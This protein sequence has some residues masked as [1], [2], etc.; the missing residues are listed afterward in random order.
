[1]RALAVRRWWISAGCALFV[2]AFVFWHFRDTLSNPALL[3]DD[4]MNIA[5]AVNMSLETNIKGFLAPNNSYNNRPLG[6]LFFSSCS[7][8]FGPNPLP[9]VAVLFGLHLAN[10]VLGF[11]LASRLLENRFLGAVCALAWAMNINLANNSYSA[12]LLYDNLLFFWWTAALLLY[13]RMRRNPNTLLY[14]GAL[15]CFFLSTRCKE[16]G[17]ML[18][19]LLL[20]YELATLEWKACGDG[21]AR[22][23]QL[24]HRL[25]LLAP[26]F[27][28][29][30]LYA[31]FY[32]WQ[33]EW[34]PGS[35]PSHPYYMNLS[36]GAFM[37]G[38]KFYVMSVTFYQSV[39]KTDLSLYVALFI[40]V[41]WALLLRRMLVLW[42]LFGF[43]VTLLPVIFLVNSR[44][45]IYLYLPLFY[46]VLILTELI[47]H[48]A[49]RLMAKWGRAGVGIAC[50]FLTALFWIYWSEDQRLL[51]YIG[52]AYQ[53]QRLEALTMVRSIKGFYP[54]IPAGSRFY[55]IGKPYHEPASIILA[56]TMPPV[57]YG[58]PTIRS[59]PVSGIEEILNREASEPDG[60]F[61]VFQFTGK[62]VDLAGGDIIRDRTAEIRKSRAPRL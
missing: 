30:L 14:V 18:P 27:V 37:E 34:G 48:T 36:Y 1:M 31:G 12:N 6:N 9:F 2:L 61:F 7:R 51:G 41:L 13:L 62:R 55:F 22:W 16:V 11:F 47:G 42:A 3:S 59:A 60:N 33:P 29:S 40:I 17:V 10:T 56:S 25:R 52:T 44:S 45:Q 49:F 54:K 46:L 21:R 5:R 39:L 8:L 28:I 32:F 57:L 53:E 26:Y 19:V 23:T 24:M 50:L 38:M 58:D 35:P 20:G 43:V 15:A 4:Y